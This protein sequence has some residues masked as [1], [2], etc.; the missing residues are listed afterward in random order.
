M[1]IWNLGMILRIATK[2]KINVLLAGPPLVLAHL[3]AAPRRML[4]KVP[5]LLGM[6]VPMILPI[7]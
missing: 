6:E 5:M 7:R 1:L 4:V 3:P 2:V